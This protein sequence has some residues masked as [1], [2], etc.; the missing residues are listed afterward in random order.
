MDVSQVTG[1]A[2]GNSSVQGMGGHH[3]HR[4]SV[5]DQISQMGSAIDKAVTAGTMTSAQAT[6]LKNELSNITT[7]L[8]QASSAS[9]TASSGTTGQSGQSNPLSALS[10]SDRKKIMSELQDVRKQL[11]SAN[12]Q[13]SNENSGEAA[14]SG[15]SISA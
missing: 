15:F 10:D 9:A 2:S 13:S 5:S 14:T 12:K 6:T 3:H 11:Y 4:K 1:N 8:S 7:T